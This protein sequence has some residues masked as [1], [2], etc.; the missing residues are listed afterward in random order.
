MVA[1]K[2]YSNDINSLNELYK[3][4]IFAQFLLILISASN[5]CIDYLRLVKTKIYSSSHNNMTQ[6]IF[7]HIFVQ[8][9]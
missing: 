3:S 8:G 9:R 2:K 1:E 5:T 6:H 4:G 7:V